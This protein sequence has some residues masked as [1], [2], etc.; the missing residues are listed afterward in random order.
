MTTALDIISDSLTFGLNR[1][2]PGE[3]LDSDLAEFS[4]NALN[5]ICDEFNGSVSMLF[6]EVLTDSGS[7]AAAYGTLGTD[8]AALAPGV[9]ILGATVRQGSED[10]PLSPLTMGQ[11]QGLGDKAL[12][13]VPEHY[14]P[15]G[16]ARVYLYPVPAGVVVT[17]RTREDVSDFADLDTDYTLPKGYKS[18]LSALLS[19][20]LAPSLG[21]LTPV[22]VQQAKAA[23]QRLAAKNINPAILNACAVRESDILRGY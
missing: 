6:R 9:K 22:V 2:S 1:L 11:Y 14:V 20:K 19:E 13:G 21:A 8:W 10:W 17:L 7:I 16:G 4:L 3:A 23:K 5:A 12:A 15:D 18:A